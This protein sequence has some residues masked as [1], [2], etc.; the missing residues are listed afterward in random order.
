MR[1]SVLIVKTRESARVSLVLRW[2]RAPWKSALVLTRDSAHRHVR[3]LVKRASPH[4]RG[5]G[6]CGAG[7]SRDEERVLVRTTE[8]AVRHDQARAGLAV[9]PNGNR[10]QMFA[11]GIIDRETAERAD[12]H[13]S[14]AVDAHAVGECG[15]RRKRLFV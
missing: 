4:R 8:C 11:R 15:A 2:W 10:A 1:T 14:S 13:I 9:T 3:N 6:E 5:S 7:A 12:V